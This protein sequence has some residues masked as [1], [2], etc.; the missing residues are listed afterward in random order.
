VLLFFSQDLLKR[1]FRFLFFVF[2]AKIY[3]EILL[4]TKYLE[5]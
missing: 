4:I 2:F 3:F 1:I 5:T